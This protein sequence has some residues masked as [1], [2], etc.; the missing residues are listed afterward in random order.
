FDGQNVFDAGDTWNHQSWQA[1]AT[2]SRLMTWGKTRPF[3]IVAIWNSP[4][5]M[6]EYYPQEPWESLTAAQRREQ[7][8][9]R[10]W[11]QQVLPVAPFSDAYLKFVTQE[12]VPAVD[13]RFAVD[14]RRDATFVMGSSMG[15]LMAW[16]AM[17]RYPARVWRRRVPFN[18]L[19]GG[20]AVAH[21]DGERSRAQ[22]LRTLHSRSLPLTCLSPNIFRSWHAHPGRVV[23]PYTTPR[24]PGTRGEG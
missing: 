1:A 24:G 16:Y 22:R 12:L 15:G 2:A 11:G 13:R 19:A 3:I 8:A 18:T 20:S 9:K 6:S 17:A 4:L 23:R 7:F 10:A 5:R 14:S 21:T